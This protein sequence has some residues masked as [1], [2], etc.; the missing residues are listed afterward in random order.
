MTKTRALGSTIATG[1]LLL[2]AFGVSSG[3]A[4]A[5][6]PSNYGDC[7]SG[8]IAYP[9]SSVGP[10]NGQ[11][12]S[13]SGRDVGGVNAAVQSGGRS[14]LTGSGSCSGLPNPGGN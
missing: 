5:A 1:V 9:A 13:S 4:A 6:P 2:A 14:K 3:V 8:G 10:S 7:V 12:L 11:A